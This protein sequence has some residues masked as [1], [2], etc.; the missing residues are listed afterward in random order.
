MPKHDIRNYIKIFKANT[1]KLS[2]GNGVT[3]PALQSP[4]SQAGVMN[5]Y[6]APTKGPK[7]HPKFVLAVIIILVII[8]L[9]LD[10]IHFGG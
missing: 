3:M 5:F 10:R 4:Q 8:I 7:L 1:C 2:R 9:I 6:D